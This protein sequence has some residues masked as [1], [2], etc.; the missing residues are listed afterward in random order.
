MMLEGS[1]WVCVVLMQERA[2]L[3]DRNSLYNVVISPIFALPGYE[4]T[5]AHRG[6]YGLSGKDGT[7]LVQVAHKKG[8]RKLSK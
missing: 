4:T 7:L 2:G 8:N 1:F 6:R 5:P 3:R